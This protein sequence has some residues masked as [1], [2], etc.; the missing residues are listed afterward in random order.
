MINLEIAITL[1]AMLVA[2]FIVI[3]LSQKGRARKKRIKQDFETLELAKQLKCDTRESKTQIALGLAPFYIKTEKPSAIDTERKIVNAFGFVIFSAFLAWSVYLFSRQFILIASSNLVFAL[4]CVL[5]LNYAKSSILKGRAG[6]S[7]LR[8][9]VD[10]YERA[11]TTAPAVKNLKQAAT[12]PSSDVKPIH[13]LYEIAQGYSQVPQDSTLKRLFL[14]NLM[15]EVEASFAP[16]PTDSMLK[17]HYDAM[18]NVAFEQRLQALSESAPVKRVKSAVVKQAAAVKQSVPE[19]AIPEDS[20][21]RRHFLTHLRSEIEAGHGSRPTDSTLKR[22][23]DTMVNAEFEQRFEALSGYT[24]QKVAEPAQKVVEPSSVHS[25]SETEEHHEHIPE[26]SMLR[27]HFLTQL[28]ST[29][30]A[31]L[32]QPPKDF[33]LLRHY[34]AMVQSKLEHELEEHYL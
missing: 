16:R 12:L 28:R 20:M 4:A 25:F 27:R 5:F 3:Y 13:E 17:R 10:E 19:T 2:F 22:H 24:A 15:T 11:I 9:A 23:F 18:L 7:Q 29:I 14:S 30:E 32:P 26:D 21:L 31:K 8:T 6:L 33:N 34:K 1:V